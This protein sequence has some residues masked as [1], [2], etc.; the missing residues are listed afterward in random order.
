[1]MLTG[2]TACQ[3]ADDAGT[4]PG[5]DGSSGGSDRI[6]SGVDVQID[7]S[8][9]TPVGIR[10]A[11][12]NLRCLQEEWDERLSLIVTE[13]AALD[14]DVIALQ[15]VCRQLLGDTDALSEL[16]DGLESATGNTYESSRADT[17]VGAGLNQEGIA[18]VTRHTFDQVE[19]VDLP[20][21]V[22]PRKGV[23]ARISHNEVSLVM[24]AT[25]L[26][27]DANIDDQATVRVSQLGMLR[28][29]MEGMRT[30][31]STLLIAGDLNEEPGG[32][33]LQA[34]TAAGY[35]DAWAVVHPDDA[36]PTFPAGDLESRI[37]YILYSPASESIRALQAQRFLDEPTN[38][39]Y[40]SDHVGLWADIGSLD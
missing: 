22:F 1:M 27:F 12:L 30:S 5:A 24:A 40:A 29:H 21:G 13:L 14:P 25:H 16:I 18:L 28:Q 20:E 7:A 23:V 6:D 36:G 34:T 2:L 39:Q 10:V 32:D 11:T 26:S 4:S 37:D 3:G 8:P 17:H 9:T 33:A 15:E 38:G 19:T 35:R 31:N